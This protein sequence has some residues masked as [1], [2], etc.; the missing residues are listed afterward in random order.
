MTMCGEAEMLRP[1]VCKLV[2]REQFSA[3]HRLHS[4]RMSKEANE[5][6]YGK[7][8]RANGHGH[9]YT[10]DVCVRGEVNYVTGMLMSLDDLKRV[11]KEEVLDDFD[12]SNLDMD[13]LEFKAMPSTTEN[14]AFVIWHRL[15]PKLGGKLHKVTVF[16][17][18]KNRASYKG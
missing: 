15:Y 14:L 2:R 3:S 9:N 6:A 5:V 7:C 17:T 16:E 4:N 11:I 8:N 13:I 18:E 12:H 10:L 1:R